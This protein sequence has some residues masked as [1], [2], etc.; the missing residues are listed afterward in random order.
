MDHIMKPEIL[1]LARPK[2]SDDY[3]DVSFAFVSITKLGLENLKKQ[4]QKCVEITNNWT[5]DTTLIAKN[6]PDGIEMYV[7]ANDDQDVLENMFASGRKLPGDDS[8]ADFV[9]IDPLSSDELD[10]IADSNI[11]EWSS[12][13]SHLRFYDDGSFCF[14]RYFEYVE[15]RLWVDRMSIENLETFFAQKNEMV[16]V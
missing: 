1:I 4:N 5:D 8:F 3:A 6:L 15:G 13:N 16:S 14:C 2:L 10:E 7:A 9:L 12:E 11:P